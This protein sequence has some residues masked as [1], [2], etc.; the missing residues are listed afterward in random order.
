MSAINESLS[1]VVEAALE[2][3][4]RR[5][6]TQLKLKSALEAGDDAEALR[7][8]KQLCGVDDNEK[9]SNSTYPS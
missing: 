6:D 1:S 9:T 3:A 8:A 2:I 7:L 5:R 4:A